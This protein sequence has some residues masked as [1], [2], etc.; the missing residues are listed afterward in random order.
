MGLCLVVFSVLESKGQAAGSGAQ[1]WFYRAVQSQGE[2][3]CASTEGND[4][5]VNC[6]TGCRHVQ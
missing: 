3:I 4:V 2:W 5:H 1:R 6:C